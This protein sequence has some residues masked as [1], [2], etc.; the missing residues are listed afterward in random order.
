MPLREYPVPEI[1]VILPVWNRAG[2]LWDC[3]QSVLGQTFNDWELII[4]DD[5][6]EDD[7]FI[8]LQPLLFKEARL[9]YLR[10]PHYG[11]PYSRNAGIQAS[12]GTY[13]TFIDSDDTYLPIH[14]ESRLS[15]MR[16]DPGIDMIQGG[17]ITDEP[18]TVPDYYR[19]GE[20]IALEEC[21]L[22]PTFF[23]KRIVFETLEGFRNINYGEDT[24]FW[25]RASHCF[26]LKSIIEPKTY[27][28]TRAK[29]SITRLKES[30][31][32]HNKRKPGLKQ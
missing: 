8:T 30:K 29:D 20:M 9:R 17:F 4:V 3:V 5:G 32:Q 6:S 11:L 24:D 12:F 25:A 28:Y 15:I 13:L 1:S 21:V 7:T 27:S 19:P 16:A 10:Q 23:G 18:V 31:N 14:L 26:T 22:G 2:H